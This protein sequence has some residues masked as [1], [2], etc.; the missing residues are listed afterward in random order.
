M[1]IQIVAQGYCSRCR[2]IGQPI[3][4]SEASLHT[5]ERSVW[6][7][8]LPTYICARGDNEFHIVVTSAHIRRADVIVDV[9]LC[10]KN[11]NLL[12]SLF[13]VSDKTSSHL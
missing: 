6:N 9:T 8:N 10:N 2:F 12:K 11:N 1:Y 7:L 13:L 3:T 4:I 5:T